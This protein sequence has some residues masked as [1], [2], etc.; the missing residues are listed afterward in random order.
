VASVNVVGALV[1]VF[2]SAINCCVGSVSSIARGA[3]DTGAYSGAFR[4]SVV[5]EPFAIGLSLGKETLSG[6]LT[7]VAPLAVHAITAT[8]AVDDVTGVSVH[9]LCDITNNLFINSYP[10]D[11]ASFF[12]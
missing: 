2:A 12:K 11:F 4:A 5:V 8:E 1:N 6:R 10:I 9:P 3:F 7:H